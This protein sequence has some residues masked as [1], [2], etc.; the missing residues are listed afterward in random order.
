MNRWWDEGRSGMCVFGARKYETDVDTSV[1]DKVVT[2]TMQIIGNQ[3]GVP[4][5]DW[6]SQAASKCVCVCCMEVL[7]WA[8]KELG[9]VLKLD[10]NTVQFKRLRIISSGC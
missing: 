4:N 5:M 3:F 2:Q 6:I 1:V 8:T 7:S 9:L 10:I